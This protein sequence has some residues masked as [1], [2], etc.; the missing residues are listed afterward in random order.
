[1]I[2]GPAQVRTSRRV[3]APPPIAQRQLR[4]FHAYTS[5]YLRRN[6]HSLRVHCLANLDQ[7]QSLPILACMNHPSWWD[8]LLAL[9]LSGH[10]FPSRSHYGPIEA[11]GASKYKFFERLGFFTI[12]K[13]SRSGA[14]RFLQIGT[15]V[16]SSPKYALWVTPQGRFTDVRQRPVSIEPGVGHLAHR[17]RKFS[18]LPVAFEYVFWNERHPE[19]LACVG[20]P[21]IVEDGRQQS[22]EHWNEVFSS[23]LGRTQDALAERA[24]R[25]D[26]TCFEALLEGASGVGGMYDLWRAF[27]SRLQGKPWQPEHENR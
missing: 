2:T 1:M 5:F 23:A 20:H 12:D 7:L 16:M 14:V 18:M 21:V 4:L 25:R 27:K 13:A 15:A 11:G 26:E 19:A 9:Y 3:S 8:P 10:F 6:F 17:L 24:Q 22:P